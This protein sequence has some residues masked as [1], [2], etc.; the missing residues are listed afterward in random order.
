MREGVPALCL[1][2]RAARSDSPSPRDAVH[3]LAS[4]CQRMK[5]WDC[6]QALLGAPAARLVHHSSP[7]SRLKRFGLQL[8]LPSP[9]H[10]SR[11][12]RMSGALVFFLP[13]PQKLP[14]LMPQTFI[15]TPFKGTKRGAPTFRYYIRTSKNHASHRVGHPSMKTEM[16]IGRAAQPLWS[17]GC[18]C[19]I[20]HQTQNVDC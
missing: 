18:P 15:G 11:L 12:R 1:A 8:E 14:N 17:A 19:R 10:D 5:L 7:R 20:K 13:V 3:S 2:E 6:R 16:G 9:S 4:L